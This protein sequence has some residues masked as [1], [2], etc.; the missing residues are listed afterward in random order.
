MNNVKTYLL[1]KHWK[2]AYGCDK[3]NDMLICC[4]RT[5]LFAIQRRCLLEIQKPV[6]GANWRAVKPARAT[7]YVNPD[8]Y[9]YV[10]L[11]LAQG[12]KWT[13]LVQNSD[14]A[15]DPQYPIQQKI[16]FSVFS[17]L[18]HEEINILLCGAQWLTK[19]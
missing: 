5:Y 10:L 15:T 8:R 1:D 9:H 17:L 18:S 19:C 12:E 16:S 14:W 11:I 4:H 13:L 6:W 2:K 3:V 7:T